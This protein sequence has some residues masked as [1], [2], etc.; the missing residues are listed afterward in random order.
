MNVLALYPGKS[1]YFACCMY[2]LHMCI[3]VEHYE[4]Q[5]TAIYEHKIVATSAH[6]LGMIVP[7]LKHQLPWKNSH[8]QTDIGMCSSIYGSS[9]HVRTYNIYLNGSCTKNS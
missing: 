9:I 2:S 1:S 7:T 8:S 6:M 4:E 5:Q 3:H